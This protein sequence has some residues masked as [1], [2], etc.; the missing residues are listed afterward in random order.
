MISTRSG[1]VAFLVDTNVLVYAYDPADRVK[2]S[3]AG[4]CIQRLTDSWNG[5]LTAQVLSE[6]FI[7]TT[8]R[9][10]PPLR[11]AEAEAILVG[12][13]R[14]WPVYEVTPLG[15]LDAIRAVQNYQFSYWDALIWATARLNGIPNVLT[16]DMPS[17][18]LIEGVRFVNPFDATFDLARLD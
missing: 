8:R 2:A 14:D 6:F 12:L 13:I 17:A 4:A 7:A 1:L 5:A 9:L 10:N 3:R 18:S 11:A 16:E 15:V